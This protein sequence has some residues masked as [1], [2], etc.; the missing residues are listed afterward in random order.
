MMDR[1]LINCPR[2]LPE[3]RMPKIIL[4]I[5]GRSMIVRLRQS[6]VISDR[7]MY[8]VKVDNLTP[9]IEYLLLHVSPSVS[10]EN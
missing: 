5:S 2:L 3:I 4:K 9:Q 7:S 10:L 1:Q 6:L 8:M